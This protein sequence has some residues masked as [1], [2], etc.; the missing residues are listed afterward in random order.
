MSWWWFGLNG[1][2]G[3]SCS[4]L[5]SVRHNHN[6]PPHILQEERTLYRNMGGMG[7]ILQTGD[8]PGASQEVFPL[9]AP[10]ASLAGGTFW[11]R[12]DK[13]V[14]ARGLSTMA[15]LAAWLVAWRACMQSIGLATTHLTH[16]ATP[17][18]PPGTPA[19]AD[20]PSR[21]WRGRSALA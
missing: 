3:C 18:N 17:S 1:W 5:P 10:L 9:T 15:W 4:S 13:C 14:G 7:Y 2:V 20:A 8:T 11:L 19:S 21:T 12:K 16:P 6:P